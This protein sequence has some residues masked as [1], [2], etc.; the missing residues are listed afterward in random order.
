MKNLEP[1]PQIRELLCVDGPRRG[2][3]FDVPVQYDRVKLRCDMGRRGTRIAVYDL[4]YL[5][6]ESMHYLT[7]RGWDDDDTWKEHYPALEAG[8]GRVRRTT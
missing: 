8:Y 6:E 4:Q 2:E 7:F 3:R 1:L 5:P